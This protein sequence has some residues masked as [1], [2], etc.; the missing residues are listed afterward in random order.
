MYSKDL[1]IHKSKEHEYR[2]IRIDDKKRMEIKISHPE[3]NEI[4]STRIQRIK[5]AL[6][7]AAAYII[8]L[9]MSAP[10]LYAGIMTL[11][12]LTYILF[13]IGSPYGIAYLFVGGSILENIV[14]MLSLIF[15]LYSVIFLYRTKSKGLVTK[16]P[17]RIVRHP[18]YFGL[19]LFTAVLTSRSIWVLLNTFGIG[20][21]R[22]WE[23]L[24]VWDFMVLVY[25][26]L[27]LFEERHLSKTYQVDWLEF[28]SQVGFFIP[29]IT[30]ERKWL[31]ALV[32][33]LVILGIITILLLSND[34]LWW[35]VQVIITL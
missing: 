12:F 17:Y 3:E 2:G 16:G 19:I 10:G 33:F 8:P 6:V 35:F 7:S 21:L 22:P 28:R 5:N 23:T 11:P 30:N 15:F 31:E 14:M 4:Q 1:V 24:A 26:G 27:A 34:T 13:M 32:S 25:I 9:V 20:Y 29:L 18:Q